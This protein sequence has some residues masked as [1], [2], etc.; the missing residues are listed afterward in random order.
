M[1]SGSENRL[2]GALKRQRRL[3]SLRN[4][5]DWQSLAYLAALPALA[6]P[7]Q[8]APGRG[9]VVAYHSACS[10]Q[11][12]QRI[13]AEPKALLR[14][15]GFTVRDVPE[16]HICCGSAGTYNILQPEISTR[17]RDRKVANIEKTKPDLIAAGN[18]GC[19]TQIGKGTGIPVI[20]TA[21]LLDWA[22]G[23]PEP[24]GLERLQRQPVH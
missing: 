6:A 11:H 2:A 23:G 8:G 24:E 16:G 10:M 9:L 5:R 15:A 17:L 1:L 4:W 7:A 14:A 18:I 20:H 13:T 22:Y 3:P 12:G 21:E 19:M